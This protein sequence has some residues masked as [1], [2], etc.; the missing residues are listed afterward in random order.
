MAQLEKDAKAELSSGPYSVINKD[1]TPP[2]GDKHDYLSQAPYFWPD[3][4]VPD[5]LPYIRRDGERNP[6]TR[7][8]H[9]RVDLGRLYEGVDALALAYYFTDDESYAAKATQLLR[10]WFLDPATK[11]NPNLEFAQFIPGANTGRGTGLIETSGLT[12]LIDA[13][14]LLQG[15]KAWTDADQ[16]GMQ[17]WFTKFLTWMQESKNGKAEAAA[18]NNHGSYYDMQLTCYALFT[19]NTELAKKTLQNVGKKRI[20]VQIEPNGR[21]PLELTRTHA[22]GYTLMN[23]NGLTTL[24][25]LGETMGIDIWNFKTD[26]GRSIQRA[27]DFL[28]PFA[29]GKQEWTYQQ[30]GGG[31]SPRGLANILRRAISHYPSERYKALLA[32]LSDENSPDWNIVLRHKIDTSADQ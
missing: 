28:V 25:G 16:Q 14:G 5:G 8:Y 20:A 18:R 23:L 15:S 17:E 9:N 21:Q 13:I 29:E 27:I 10:T 11:M 1:F 24:A 32:K 6:E 4:N 30:L 19:G 22:W 12:R 3:P 7:K 26:D 31:W 2:S